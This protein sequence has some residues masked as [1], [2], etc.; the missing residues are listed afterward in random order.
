MI[1]IIADTHCHTT[2]STHA[3]SSALEMITA[4]KKEGLYAIA[5][6]DHARSMPGAPGPW[7][8]ENLGAIPRIVDGVRV[9]RGIEANV[10]DYDGTLDVDDGLLQKMDWVVASMHDP[11]L[12][13]GRGIEACTNAWLR[14]AENPRV[15]VIGHCGMET[16]RFDYE[17]VLRAFRDNGKLVEINNHT[18]EARQSAVS[19]CRTIAKLC[20]SAGV[21]IIINSDAHFCTQVGHMELAFSMLREIDFPESLI[22]NADVARLQDYLKKYTP[23]PV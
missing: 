17:R 18:F 4:A 1:K 9:L 2:A 21:P 20:K 14:V 7:F 8:F 5:L 3:Y 22:V 11:V 16:Y 10:V 12:P 19:N 23:F 15:N 13:G 6:T